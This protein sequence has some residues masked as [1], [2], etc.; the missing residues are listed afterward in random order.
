MRNSTITDALFPR[1]RKR[2]LAAL[3]L[4]PRRHCYASELARLLAVPP[5]TLQRDLARLTAAGIFKMSRSGNR[6][7]FQ[8]DQSCPIFSEL[9]SL[10]LKSDL[11][12]R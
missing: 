10:L 11:E 8:A 7:Y 9:R 5:S 2:L 4:N 6:T 3:L 12:I 1:V